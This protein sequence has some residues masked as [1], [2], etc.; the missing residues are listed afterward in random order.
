MD[1]GRRLTQGRLLIEG[2]LQIPLLQDHNGSQPDYG[3]RPALGA[4]FLFS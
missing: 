2:S 1:L 3:V 4:R